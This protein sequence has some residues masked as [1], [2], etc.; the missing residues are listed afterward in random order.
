MTGLLPDFIADP[1]GTPLTWVLGSAQADSDSG[2]CAVSAP[3]ACTSNG[4][5]SSVRCR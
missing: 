1:L 4:S 3:I 2:R 5:G